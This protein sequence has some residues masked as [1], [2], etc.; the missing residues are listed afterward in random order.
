MRESNNYY[1][2]KW[3]SFFATV[4]ILGVGILGAM[5]LRR[6]SPAPESLPPQEESEIQGQSGHYTNTAFGQLIEQN[7]SELGFIEELAFEGKNEGR[8]SLTGTLSNPARL[9][10]ICPDLKSADMVLNSLKGKQIT[11]NGHLGE[12]ENGNGQFVTDTITFSGL[13]IPAGIATEYIEQYT[14]LNSL[15]EVPMHQININETGVSFSNE[16]PTAIQIASYNPQ[17]SSPSEE[18]TPI[19]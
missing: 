16:I 7:L 18:K 11:I 4:L 9:T 3:G 13:T 1:R 8:F 19:Q 6:G 15:L 5:L 10:A 14:S 17:A 12:N 2:I